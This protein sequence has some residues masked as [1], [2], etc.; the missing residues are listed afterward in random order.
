MANQSNN[1]KKEQSEHEKKIILFVS[2]NSYYYATT[3]E[4]FQRLVDSLGQIGE[5]FKV[6]IVDVEKNPELAEKYNI[7]VE[8]TIIIGEK[9][10]VGR[11]ENKKVAEYM[12]EYFS[13]AIKR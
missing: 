1:T 11:F 5:K 4:N 10:F 3:I 7:L 13:R 9:Y 6:K 8:P 12:K 2:N